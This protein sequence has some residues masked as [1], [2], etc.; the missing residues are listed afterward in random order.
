MCIW[1]MYVILRILELE[2][3]PILQMRKN[4]KLA[5]LRDLF[6]V[7]MLLISISDELPSQCFC[8]VIPAS[9]LQY[10]F[11]SV[12]LLFHSYNHITVCKNERGEQP[13]INLLFLEKKKKKSPPCQLD[14][15][16]RPSPPWLMASARR[17][18]D[19]RGALRPA[20][21]AGG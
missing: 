17:K 9:T 20:V 19:P 6:K 18:A 10:F 12:L 7:T 11:V 2:C 13:R 21:P 4:L 8:H 16:T 5:I 3:G 15:C 1:K 14:G